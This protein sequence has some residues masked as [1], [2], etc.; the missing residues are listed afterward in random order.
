MD[1]QF[2]IEQQMFIL[3]LKV[4]WAL[5]VTTEDALN[6]KMINKDN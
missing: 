3:K 4:H 2:F 6:S 1:I 5:T